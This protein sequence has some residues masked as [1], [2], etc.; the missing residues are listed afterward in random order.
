MVWKFPSDSKYDKRLMKGTVKH[1]KSVMVWVCFSWNR[2]GDLC[3]INGTMT[4]KTY[5]KI[6]QKHMFPSYSRL[7]GRK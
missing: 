4:A 7:F 3:R 2:T 6:L 5:H 1:G